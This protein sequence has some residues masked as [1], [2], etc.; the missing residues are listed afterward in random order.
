MI[1]TEKY[2]CGDAYSI[3][4]CRDDDPCV[5]IYNRD[6]HMAIINVT[7]DFSLLQGLGVIA[8]LA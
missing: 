1:K 5:K 6:T 3:M 7:E 2:V 4:R 8:A